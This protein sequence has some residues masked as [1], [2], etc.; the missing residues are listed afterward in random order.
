MERFRRLTALRL[1]AWSAT[2]PGFP[3]KRLG[4]HLGVLSLLVVLL[5]GGGLRG[6]LAQPGDGSANSGG[7]IR[8]SAQLRPGTQEG[9]ALSSY[10]SIPAVPVM[11]QK[12]RVSAPETALTEEESTAVP[13]GTE[14][15]VYVVREGDTLN[16]IAAL[17][18][19]SIETLYWFNQLENADFLSVG[20]EL[21]IPPMDGLLHTVAAGETLESIAEDYGVRR[22]NMIAYAGNDLREPYDLEEGQELF[23]PWAAKPIPIEAEYKKSI[24]CG[25]MRTAT[26]A[27]GL[28]PGGQ[29]FSWP[30][31]G[32]ITELF[33]WTGTRCH[34]GLDIA[35][36]WGS[37]VYAA[38]EGTVVYSGWRGNL[39]YSVEIDHGNGWATRY[40]H[41]ASY[42]EV[43]VG[44]WVE[45]GQL[46]G[47]VG[48]TGYS[49]GPHLH[50]EV[51]YYGA[52]CD[53]LSYLP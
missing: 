13:L 31:R 17:Y 53:P 26:P 24:G 35:P 11:I 46:I 19:L 42:P 27:Y 9:D 43:S 1:S 7:L 52:Y 23:V 29:R 2:S 28:L 40:G 14:V 12:P 15:I 8:V 48:R 3:W 45:R 36:P 39:G 47:F 5:L 38:A 6:V 25:W 30:T 21:D 18:S 37:D 41:L 32:P 10:V 33:G 16:S 20:R 44:D 50:F 34:T 4:A 49:T 22:G 51:I